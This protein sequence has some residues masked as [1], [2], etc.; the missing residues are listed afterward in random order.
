[1]LASAPSGALVLYYK[2]RRKTWTQAR[3]PPSLPSS[4]LVFICWLK[5]CLVLLFR[6]LTNSPYE[7]HWKTLGEFDTLEEAQEFW[8]NLNGGL[9]VEK[10]LDGVWALYRIEEGRDGG[11]V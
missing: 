1:M 2:Q 3:L 6:L 5:E 8:D 9:P 4:R 11:F 10:I 7:S